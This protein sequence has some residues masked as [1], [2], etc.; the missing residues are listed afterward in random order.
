MIDYMRNIRLGLLYFF[1]ITSFSCFLDERMLGIALTGYFLIG[2]LWL[3]QNFADFDREN[4][5]EE[6]W[7]KG[8]DFSGTNS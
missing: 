2:F 6:Y 3:F 4:S 1:V 5:N 8:N 7:G